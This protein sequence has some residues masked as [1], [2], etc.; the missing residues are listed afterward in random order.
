MPAVV[1]LFNRVKAVNQAQYQQLHCQ[2]QC[3]GTTMPVHSH[4]VQDDVHFCY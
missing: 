1:K 3:V 4:S 2:D